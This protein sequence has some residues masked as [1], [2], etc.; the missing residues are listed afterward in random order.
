[1]SSA[2]PNNIIPN[3]S[4]C[5]PKRHFL[6]RGTDGGKFN[7]CLWHVVVLLNSKQII[8]TTYSNCE[9]IFPAFLFQGSYLN[10]FLCCFRS[11]SPAQS[12]QLWKWNAYYWRNTTFPKFWTSPNSVAFIQNSKWYKHHSI[13]LLLFFHKTF[14]VPFCDLVTRRPSLCIEPK[15]AFVAHRAAA[16]NIACWTSV[17]LV[18]GKLLEGFRSSWGVAGGAQ[19]A[20]SSL[21]FH[22]QK[23][24]TVRCFKK[25]VSGLEWCK[26]PDSFWPLQI[27]E[28]KSPGLRLA[29]EWCVVL[30]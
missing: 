5:V 8:E 15:A 27:C 26:K 21:G 7:D 28:E 12:Y 2:K 6:L 18:D 29:E 4:F 23:Q 1:M 16:I 24:E 3:Q 14:F 13:H 19:V 17:S 30:R 25:P 9:G 11:R 20:R 10:I 22:V